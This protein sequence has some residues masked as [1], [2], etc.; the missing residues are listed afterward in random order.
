MNAEQFH[1]WL[2]TNGACSP[3]VEFAK[4]RTLQEAW[5]TC[6]NPSWMYWLG[7]RI[8]K[9]RN[10]LLLSLCEIVESVLPVECDL[11]SR[12]ALEAVRG[13]VNGTVTRVE[14]KLAAA[15]ADADADAADARKTKYKIMADKLIELLEAA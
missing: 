1:T 13:Y 2:V 10:P 6:P 8:L 12:K 9:N 14:V 15:D 3:A 5:D 7:F 11:R 4:G